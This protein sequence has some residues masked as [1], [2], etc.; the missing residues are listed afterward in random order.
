[1]H[2]GLIRAAATWPRG[3]HRKRSAAPPLARSSS[4]LELYDDKYDRFPNTSQPLSYRDTS[5]GLLIFVLGFAP[6]RAR[7]MLSAR[8]PAERP[9][10]FAY[11][12]SRR[13]YRYGRHLPDARRVT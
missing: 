2:G 1:M 3:F 6:A 4:K 7:K 11:L 10:T 5:S 8:D 9:G 12:N 13:R